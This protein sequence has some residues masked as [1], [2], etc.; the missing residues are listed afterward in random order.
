MPED[1]ASMNCTIGWNC[2]Q[3]VLDPVIVVNGVDPFRKKHDLR[4]SGN[5][6]TDLKRGD[7]GPL[8][9]VRRGLT[10]S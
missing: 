5:Q 1:V 4:F 3:G 9:G 2:T 7:V 10:R 6:A 8:R